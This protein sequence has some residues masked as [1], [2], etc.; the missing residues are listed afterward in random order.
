MSTLPESVRNCLKLLTSD[1]MFLIISNMT[2]LKLHPLAA[3]SDSESDTEAST[4]EP[5]PKKSKSNCEDNGGKSWMRLWIWAKSSFYAPLYMSW[6]SFRP[7]NF[8]FIFCIQSDG[9]CEDLSL[10]SQTLQRFACASRTQTS[11]LFY[12]NTSSIGEYGA[13]EPIK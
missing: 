2:G 6:H 8:F 7:S 12:I 3:D 9:L 11:T 10:R 13:Q 5:K 1:A 4:S